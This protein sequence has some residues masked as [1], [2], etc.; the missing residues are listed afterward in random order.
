M[1][2]PFSPAALQ[3]LLQTLAI[4][5]QGM[6]GIFVFMGLVYLVIK[7]LMKWGPRLDPKEKKKE[8]D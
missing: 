4:M 7:G 8:G 3:V 2:A 1:N 5:G 6:F